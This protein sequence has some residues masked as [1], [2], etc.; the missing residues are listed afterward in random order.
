MG[1]EFLKDLQKS[2]KLA[3]AAQPLSKNAFGNWPWMSY[4]ASSDVESNGEVP[5]VHNPAPRAPNLT[6][7]IR[8]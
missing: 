7:T 2:G 6:R 5:R 3:R 8:K 1:N 4:G